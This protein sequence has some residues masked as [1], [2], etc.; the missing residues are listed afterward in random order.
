MSDVQD[1]LKALLGTSG[2]MS[3]AAFRV[4]SQELE[5]QRASGEFE[6]GK[7]VPGE[8]IGDAND[9]F[10]LVRN[11]FPIDTPHGNMTLGSALQADARHIAVS[12]NDEELTAFDPT[13]AVFVDT[14]T[15]G[16]M[17]G[18][19]TVAFLV[20]V[21]YFTEDVFR[22]DQCFMRDYD[23]EEP[24]LEYLNG[25]FENADTLVSYN[26]KTF[27]LP[28][29]RARFITNRTPF[30]LESAMHLDL[31]HAARRFWKKRLGDCSLGNIESAIL[32]IQRHGDV[33]GS[34][35]PQLWLNYLHTRDAR[36]LE[37]VFYHHKMDIL[38]LAAL[39]GYLS[40]T[41]GAQNGG[42]FE[43]IEDRL[44]L[45]RVHYNQKRYDDVLELADVLLGETDE[46]ILI[47]ECLEMAGFAAK[48]RE[49]W[50]RM[51]DFWTLLVQQSP[52]HV[53]AC[54]ELAKHYEHRKR[55]LPAAERIC[56]GAIQFLET[57]GAL[58]ETTIP[59]LTSLQHRLER[60]QRKLGRP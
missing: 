11:D 37:P 31:V 35:I 40:Q 57:Q 30:R 49:Q 43:H 59:A 13:T 27:D 18:S 21:G 60:I 39:T 19:G 2:V 12:A 32:G 51:E 58:F 45:I 14:E 10:F 8:V 3:G 23:D 25:L 44:S 22:L 56:Q 17:G 33:A 41:L 6:I 36:R 7:V 29:L 38:S 4:K 46:Q 26:G 50:Q 47:C 42:G 20:G 55:D 5:E 1:K 34:E 9:G 15:T 16:L 54:H 52:R 53:I 28:L 48:R 24:M